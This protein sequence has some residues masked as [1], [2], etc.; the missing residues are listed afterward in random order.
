MA[1]QAAL[2]MR[3]LASIKRGIDKAA[4][5]E[6][7]STSSLVEK[8]LD[9]YLRAAKTGSPRKYARPDEWTAAG[10]KSTGK[11]LGDAT[12]RDP[13]SYGMAE[14]ETYLAR[15]LDE[16]QGGKNGSQCADVMKRRPSPTRIRFV[17]RI[18]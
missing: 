15:K 5:K 12:C 7:L 16:R 18:D 1:K 8:I 10:S 2:S 14:A 6:H 9:D 13:Q 4:S 3:I 11:K 17:R